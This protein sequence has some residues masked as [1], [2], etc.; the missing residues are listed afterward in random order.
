VNWLFLTCFL[1]SWPGLYYLCKLM[2]GYIRDFSL[3]NVCS[4]SN[5]PH[6]ARCSS[7]S[8][9]CRGIDVFG[10]KTVSLILY[11]HAFLLIKI[12]V[13]FHMN[14]CIFFSNCI[15]IAA[16]ERMEFLLLYKWHKLPGFCLL[17]VCMCLFPLF[18]SCIRYNLPLAC[19]VS[20]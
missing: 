4:S 15:M 17:F 14:I 9:V 12:L 8:N 1:V 2:L 13:V 10:T 19:W 11:S 18:C 20:T 3:F 7:P 6:P 16:I 5:N